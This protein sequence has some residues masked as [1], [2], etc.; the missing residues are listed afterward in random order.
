M[1]DAS[2]VK[3]RVQAVRAEA[4]Q[5]IQIGG[6]P[7]AAVAV[8]HNGDL[9]HTEFNGY[10]D[11]AKK[12]PIDDQIVFPCASLTKAVVS[13]AVAVCV[14]D[15]KFGWD[16]PVKDILPTFHT[17]SK[18]LQH[19]MTPVDRLSHRAGMQNPLIWLGNENRVFI[20]KEHSF[21][22]VNDLQQVK[23]FRNGFKYNNLGYEIA[24][25]IFEAAT[26]QPWER[27]IH[28]FIL[29]PLEMTRTGTHAYF[30]G[31]ENVAK[32]YMALDDASVVEVTPM[33]SGDD[34]VSGPGSALR[35]C[36]RD[37]QVPF[38]FT[39][40]IS[41]NGDSDRETSYA[42]GWAR[43]QTPGP[44]GAIGFNPELLRYQSMK[45]PNVARDHPSKFIFHHQ[46]Y[47]PGS[48]S[49]LTNSPGLID[50]ADLLGQLYLEAYLG[51]ENRNDYVSRARL[52]ESRIL[53]TVHRDLP[54]YA[55]RFYNQARTM[56]LDI[57]SHGQFARR[58]RLTVMTAKFAD[59]Y[60]ICFGY[61]TQTGL[62][63]F[64][65]WC[66]EE[67]LIAPERFFKEVA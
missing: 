13:A 47:M 10:Q 41:M 67:S 14:D 2:Q 39:P 66:Y 32:T 37:L 38:P 7:G 33:L 43:V 49:V 60:K 12:T 1:D 63:S 4:E 56:M 65:I 52:Q 35:S 26:G 3:A 51:V 46:G 25:H 22:F 42:L 45:V 5:L 18:V 57:S 31:C 17:R 8:I 29:Q 30:C 20:T 24:S 9:I 40:Q 36:V 59:Y 15:G 34:T 58:G 53:G 23:P 50:V 55:G 27:I 28:S 6:T 19:Q 64:L 62:I 21:N 11:T 54:D 16:T 61:D 44:M 48:V